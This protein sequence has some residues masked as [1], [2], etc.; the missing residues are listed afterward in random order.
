M[1]TLIFHEKDGCLT[2][3]NKEVNKW[4]VLTSIGRYKYF[5]NKVVVIGR[6]EELFKG[7]SIKKYDKHKEDIKIHDV[8]I[9]INMSAKLD[10]SLLDKKSKNKNKKNER[11]SGR[12]VLELFKRSYKEV[13]EIEYIMSDDKKYERKFRT[14]IDNFHLS[15]LKDIHLRRYIS[16]AVRFGNHNGDAIYIDWLFNDNVVQNYLLVAKGIKDITSVWR[17]LDVSLSTL[18]KKKIKYIMNLRNFDG[19][20]EIEKNMCL[21]L[22]K[23]YDKKIYN[24]LSKKHTMKNNFMIKKELFKL[25]SV[26]YEI[27]MHTLLNKTKHSDKYFW[28]EFT[29]GQIK[30]A[31]IK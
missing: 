31:L 27:P 3:K 19:L 13:H 16:R 22:Y 5:Y 8:E 7:L 4:S 1:K 30:E 29:R 23:K 9:Y 20:D 12:S 14:L 26:E 6:H 25:L 11:L 17:Y 28:Y 2:C 21:K 10:D 15:E 18:E 24:E